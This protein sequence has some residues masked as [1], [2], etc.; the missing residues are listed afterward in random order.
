[1]TDWESP[2][3]ILPEYSA[4]FIH[5]KVLSSEIHLYAPAAYFEVV[6]VLFGLFM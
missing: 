4:S 2:A 6:H 1:M 3:V 5:A